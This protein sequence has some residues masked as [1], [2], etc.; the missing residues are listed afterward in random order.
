VNC[1]SDGDGCGSYCWLDLFADFSA[2]RLKTLPLSKINFRNVKNIKIPS[3][4]DL[5]CLL[6]QLPTVVSL[7]NI[8]SNVISTKL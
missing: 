2:N 4:H 3:S 1:H 5:D 6:N 7:M 8:R